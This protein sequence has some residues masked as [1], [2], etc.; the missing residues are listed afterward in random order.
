MMSQAAFF[1]PQCRRVVLPSESCRDCTIGGLEALKSMLVEE[2]CFYQRKV[3]YLSTRCGSRLVEVVEA[4]EGFLG[5]MRKRVSTALF[6]DDC[7]PLRAFIPAFLIRPLTRDEISSVVRHQINATLLQV[8]SPIG[9][10]K[11][12]TLCLA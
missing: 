9:T 10:V 5:Y 3:F 8:A 2:T 7:H 1:L 4:V 6:P 11:G 12:V